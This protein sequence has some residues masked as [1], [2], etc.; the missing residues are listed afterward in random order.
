MMRSELKGDYAKV[1]FSFAWVRLVPSYYKLITVGLGLPTY[2]YGS[3]ISNFKTHSS[4][5]TFESTTPWSCRGDGA[6]NCICS[7]S[8]KLFPLHERRIEWSLA[9]RLGLSF[10]RSRS[11]PSTTE[12]SIMKLFITILSHCLSRGLTI[13]GYMR[14]MRGGISMWELSV[15]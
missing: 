5:Q 3:L 8:S 15:V 4:I 10:V 13:H 11:G 9:P 7:S 12:T 1:I 6:H 2:F 14:H